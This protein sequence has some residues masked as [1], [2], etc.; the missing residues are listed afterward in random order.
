MVM[1]I[2]QVDNYIPVIIIVLASMISVNN[3]QGIAGTDLQTLT[4]H[5]NICTRILNKPIKLPTQ[6]SI[7]MYAPSKQT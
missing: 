6:N 5:L 3:S 1:C 2:F 7:T 4:R